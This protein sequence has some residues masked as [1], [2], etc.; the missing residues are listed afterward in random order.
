LD[1]LPNSPRYSKVYL[2]IDFEIEILFS[3]KLDLEFG[4]E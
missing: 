2:G 4:I 1:R 3:S